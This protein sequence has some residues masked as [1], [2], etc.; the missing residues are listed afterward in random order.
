[1]IWTYLRACYKFPMRVY[2]GGR[3]LIVPARWYFCER[4]AKAFPGLHGAEA[5]PWLKQW[6]TN[7]DWGEVTPEG[8]YRKFDKGQNHGYAGQCFVGDRRWFTDGQLPQSVLSMPPVIPL[9]DCCNPKMAFGSGQLILQ[10]TATPYQRPVPVGTG[11]LILRGTSHPFQP[12]RLILGGGGDPF[13]VPYPPPPLLGG[14]LILQGTGTPFQSPPPPA[15]SPS[16]YSGIPIPET[17]ECGSCPDGA[18]VQYSFTP[19]GVTDGECTGCAAL[20]QPFTLTHATACRWLSQF[21]LYCSNP[22]QVWE[23]DIRDDAVV[24]SSGVTMIYSVPRG[25]WDCLTPL[26]LTRQT[27]DAGCL[28]LPDTLTLTPV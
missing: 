19:A 14:Q 26:A 7:D 1:M 5:S 8:F 22:S 13:Q 20:N 6:E 23:L 10:G 3:E 17:P 25:A 15:P 18:A 4:G 24:L 9:P 12:G 28:G 11:Q 21:Y 27:V 16:Y 2:V